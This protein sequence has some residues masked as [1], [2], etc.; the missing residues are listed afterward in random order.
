[1]RSIFISYRRDDAEG[2]AGRLYDDLARHLNM[3]A[4][5]LDTDP[6]P[7]QLNSFDLTACRAVRP[8]AVEAP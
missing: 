6:R 3:C 2:Q 4:L 1:M 7:G 8:S 5:H